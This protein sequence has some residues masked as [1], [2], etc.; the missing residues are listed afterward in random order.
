[1]GRRERMVGGT[2]VPSQSDL[3]NQRRLAQH[4]FIVLVAVLFGGG[5]TG[6]GCVTQPDSPTPRTLQR[7]CH[8][9]GLLYC[10][11][12]Y[13]RTHESCCPSETPY[14]NPCAAVTRQIPSP[15]GGFT[16]DFPACGRNTSDARAIGV[17]FGVGAN[18]SSI[19]GCS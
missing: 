14:L 7:E 17:G 5:A 2:T 13:P 4:L 6:N 1:M 18:C 12:H 16:M 9:A 10:S 11:G 8:D 19:D 15:G 3:Q